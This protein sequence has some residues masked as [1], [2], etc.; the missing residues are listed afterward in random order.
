MN[1]CPPGPQVFHWGRFEFFRKFAEIFAN[2]YLSQVSTTP[3]INCS[4]VST[5]PAKNLSPVSTTPANNPCDGEI[6]KKPNIFR[7]C[8]ISKKIQ[9]LGEKCTKLSSQQNMKKKF[10]SKFFSFFA[11]VLDIADKHSFANISANFR[12]NSKWS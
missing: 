1:Q 4:E 6:T 5:T 8:Q 11:G 7:R 10:I 2:E 12:K 9:S 3:A